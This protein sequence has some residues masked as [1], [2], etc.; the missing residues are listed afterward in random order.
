MSAQKTIPIKN[1]DVPLNRDLFL[2]SLIRELSGVLQDVVGMDDASGFVSIVGQNIGSHINREYKSALATEKLTRSEVAAVL[3]N[4]K[5]R[6][7]GGFHVIE[8][9]D[10]KLVF[11][12]TECPFGDYV[13]DRPSMCMMTSNVFGTIASENLGYAKVVIEEAIATNDAR[14]RVV[15]HLRQSSESESQEGREYFDTGV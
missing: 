3:E 11:G 5:L 13:K 4:L 9:D 10:E 2:R 12:N 15:V 7:H 6:I 1:L 14:C 8:Q